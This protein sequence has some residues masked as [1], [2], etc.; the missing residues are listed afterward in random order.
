VWH[1]VLVQNS[2]EALVSMADLIELI[3]V[4]DI[5]RSVA[6][7]TLLAALYVLL[8]YITLATPPKERYTK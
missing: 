6:L 8:I 7:V 1:A 3:P 4:E 2:P 5:V